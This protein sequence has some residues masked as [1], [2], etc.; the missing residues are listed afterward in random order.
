MKVHLEIDNFAAIKQLYD[1]M[2]TSYISDLMLFTLNHYLRLV[3]F[4][5]RIHYFA[6]AFKAQRI[7]MEATIFKSQSYIL[8]SVLFI[9]ILVL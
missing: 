3:T 9:R 4:Y 1:E 6:I 8:L 2:K 5:K 7:S